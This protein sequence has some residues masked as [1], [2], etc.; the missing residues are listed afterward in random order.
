VTCSVNTPSLDDAEVYVCLDAL[1][2]TEVNQTFARRQPRQSVTR[3]SPREDL[4]EGWRLCTSLKIITSLLI[5]F[6]MIGV[7]DKVLFNIRKLNVI[8]IISIENLVR[9]SQRT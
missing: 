4:I 2:A 7:I 1:A 8:D 5:Q 3:L 6:Y 9:S